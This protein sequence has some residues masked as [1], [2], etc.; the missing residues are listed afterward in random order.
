MSSVSVQRGSSTV[1][2]SLSDDRLPWLGGLDG[3]EYGT[4]LPGVEVVLYFREP[5]NYE[6]KKGLEIAFN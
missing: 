4:S 3:S 1:G 6:K 2:Y 5:K